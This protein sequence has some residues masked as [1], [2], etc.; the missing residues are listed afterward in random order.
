MTQ[1]IK[2]EDHGERT[3]GKCDQG[4]QG[5]LSRKELYVFK[6]PS[7]VNRLSFKACQNMESFKDALK[8][9]TSSNPRTV[10]SHVSSDPKIT[11]GVES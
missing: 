10:L 3:L 5:T 1:A 2:R 6:D 8:F 11:N 9:V 4:D 7:G